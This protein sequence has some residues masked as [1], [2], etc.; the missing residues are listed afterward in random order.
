M[1]EDDVCVDRSLPSSAGE[2][3]CDDLGVSCCNPGKGSNIDCR[4][5]DEAS[6]LLLLSPGACELCEVGWDGGNE[7]S[8]GAFLPVRSRSL[9]SSTL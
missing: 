5:I 6:V 2:S 8:T 7:T 4:E 3:S 1:V 9:N